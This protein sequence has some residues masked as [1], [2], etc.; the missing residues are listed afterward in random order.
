M[1]LCTPRPTG[2]MAPTPWLASQYRQQ[3]SQRMHAHGI[4]H[5]QRVVVDERRGF[6]VPENLS[7]SAPYSATSSPS[8]VLTSPLPD[9]T[10]ANGQFEQR[11]PGGHDPRR[12]RGMTCPGRSGV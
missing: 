4:V 3:R 5:Q 10:P 1:G 8:R 7:G 9:L 12:P 11:P 2:T 6:L